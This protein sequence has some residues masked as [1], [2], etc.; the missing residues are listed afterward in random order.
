MRAS[1]STSIVALVLL[2]GSAFAAPGYTTTTSA[3]WSPSPSVS[4]YHTPYPPKGPDNYGSCTQCVSSPNNCDITAPCSNFL[5][6]LYCGCRPGYKAGTAAYTIDNA[7]TTMQWRIDT[8]PGHEH[9]VWVA[10]G[11][12]C[13]QLCDSPYGPT[14]CSEVAIQDTCA[15]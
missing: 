8:E 13:D 2:A 12:V 10:P 5:G 4:D 6:K 14:P 1:I 9:R 11:A 7:D 3:S 15:P